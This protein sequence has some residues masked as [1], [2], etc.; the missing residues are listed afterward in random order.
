MAENE[1]KVD[2][3]VDDELIEDPEDV[4]EAKDGETDTTD[5]KALAAKNAGIAKR[6]KT[7]LEKA[8]LEKKVDKK[9]E[10]KLAETNKGFDYGQKAFLKASGIAPSEYA[11]VQEVMS[12]TGK[13]LESVLDSKYFQAELKDLREASATKEAVPAGQKRSTTSTRE[14]VDYWIAKGELP[15]ADQV[16][17][18]RKVVNAKIAQ[19]RNKSVFAERSVV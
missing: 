6:L 17:L 2:A 19:A 16:E 5:Y 7:K 12:A 11:L 13:D 4:K 3:V 14:T 9:V 15:P 1:T 8:K 10:Q 18:R